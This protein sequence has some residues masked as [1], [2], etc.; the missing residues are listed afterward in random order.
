MKTVAAILLLVVGVAWPLGWLLWLAGRLN[1]QPPMTP[2]LLGLLL[3]LNFVVPISLILTALR[4]LLEPLRVSP[5]F[6]GVLLIA[7]AAVPVLA[8]SAWLATKAAPGGAE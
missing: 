8:I 1:R 4:L 5:V 7:W 3:A 6:R 2:R